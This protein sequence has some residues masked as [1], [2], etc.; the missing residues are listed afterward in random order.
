[1][2]PTRGSAS[3]KV[4]SASPYQRPLDAYLSEIA[5]GETTGLNTVKLR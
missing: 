4:R 5:S 2:H 3:A 1:V